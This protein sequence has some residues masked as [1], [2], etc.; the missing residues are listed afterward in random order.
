MTHTQRTKLNEGWHFQFEHESAE[1]VTLPHTWNALDTMHPDPAQHYRRGVGVY[2]RTIS[3]LKLAA[4]ERLWLEIEA[5]AQKAY[6][7]LN[8]QRIAEHL[9]GY[10]PFTVELTPSVY[11]LPTD[12]P[13]MLRIETDN[14]PDRDL[15]P[16]DMS[17]FF[18]Y[19][20]LTRNVWLYKTG[21]L[22]IERLHVTPHMDG[23][24]IVRGDID[25]SVTEPLQVQITA[26]NGAAVLDE[27]VSVIEQAFT[28]DA[29]LPVQAWSPDDPALYRLTARLGSSDTVSLAFGFR[30]VSFPPGGPFFLNDERLLLRGTHRHEDWAGYGSAVPDD[31]SRQELEQ[32]KAAGF[33]FIRLGHYPQAPAVLQACDTLGLLVW[34]E[35]PWCR[36]GI[37]G[38]TFQQQTRTMLREMIDIYYNH[39][40]IIMWGLGNELDWESEHEG[41]SDEKVATFLGELNN[42]SHELDPNRL[43]AIRRFEPGA[44]IVDVYSPSIWSGWYRGRYEDYE[45]ALSHALAMYPNFFHAEWG[46]DS[47]VGRHNVGPHLQAAPEVTSDHGEVP[48][49]ATSSDG[50]ARASRDSDW[51]ESYMLDVMEWHLQVHT[52]TPNLSGSAQWIFSDFGTPLRPEN[53][54]PYINQKGLVTRAGQRKDVYYLFQS[55]QTTAPMVYIESPSWPIRSGDAPQRVRIY[56]N[57][58]QVTLYVNNADQ[59]TLTRDPSAFPAAGLVWHVPFQAGENHLRAVGHIPEG[60]TIEHIITQR[61]HAPQNEPAQQ[62][63]CEHIAFGR[64]VIQLANAEGQPVIAPE[65]FL[66]ISVQSGGVLCAEQGTLDG[67]RRVQTANGRAWITVVADGTPLKFHI[68]AET[69]A[70]TIQLEL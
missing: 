32:V 54:I 17:D 66:Q 52:R 48:G 58:P 23:R 10:I 65:Q 6:I 53:P 49:L 44:A 37:G 38:E 15:I 9:G 7:Y 30:T 13:L 43:T 56:S 19:G 27:Q 46:G 24:V 57:C 39:P 42:L 69:F 63:L 29:E 5:A 28:L 2:T 26:P 40:S 25:G 68:Q 41:S 14:R 1:W 11:G 16:S 33:N 64:I 22:H 35:L 18:L 4:D 70:Q 47:H 61:L 55:Y 21:S 50:F 8:D 34:L 20:G 36:G 59:G 45:T 31:L 60:K 3:S 67:A 62:L 12:K 51:S